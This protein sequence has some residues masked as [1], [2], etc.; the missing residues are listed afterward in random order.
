MPAESNRPSS[1]LSSARS[2][3]QVT[4]RLGTMGMAY[5]D[6]RGNFYP[7]ALPQ[8][9]WLRSYA[10]QLGALE[11]NTTFYATPTPA[12][13]EAWSRATPPSFRFAVKVGRHIT[14]DVPLAEAADPLRA[15]IDAVRPLG[16]R[17][18]PLLI[19]LGPQHTARSL[20]SLV[21]LLKVLPYDLQFALELRHR[22]WRRRK[23][24]AEVTALLRR[25]YVAL[26]GLDHDDY[27]EQAEL[28]PTADFLY[29]R[30]VGGHGR[31]PTDTHERRDPTPALVHWHEMILS[32]LTPETR[33]VWVL[34]NNEYAG[35]AP[36]TLRR[37]ARLAGI[38]LPEP[39][40]QQKRLFE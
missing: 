25:Q 21:R 12:R 29:I 30:L 32:A 17:L 39:P 8:R 33:E 22:S 19:Q 2:P 28:V 37:F 14:H 1:S 26:V 31:Y 20:P 24:L 23:V 38:A 15:F 3:P 27:P 34:F 11:L 35:H 9:E 7:P 18:G 16:V 6:W 10:A 4:W 36:S 5:R 40:P 13:L